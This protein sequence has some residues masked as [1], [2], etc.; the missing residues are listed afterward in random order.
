[1]SMKKFLALSMSLLM[2]FGT[3]QTALAQV[4][5]LGEPVGITNANGVLLVTD[6]SDNV[7][8]RI[9]NGKAAVYSGKEAVEDIYGDA[10]E[11]YYDGGVRTA[12]YGDPWDIVPYMDG[13]AVT[14]TASMLCVILVKIRCIRW[15]AAKK[16][17]TRTAKA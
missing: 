15:S 10:M 11:Y 3:C 2:L 1:M 7:I 5:V 17:A 6:K 14:D 8:Y 13:Y 9:E 4:T 12:Y 16:Q